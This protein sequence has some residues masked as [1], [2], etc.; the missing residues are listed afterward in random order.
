MRVRNKPLV[1]LV[2]LA[3]AA[4]ALAGGC[5]SD[6][7]SE[8]SQPP[9]QPPG[10]PPTGQ[11]FNISVT[12][13]P[14]T[15]EA[16][17]EESA[18]IRVEVRRTDNNQPPP[19]GTTVVISTTL[20]SLNA[21]G[22]PQSDVFELV[23]GVATALFFPPADP[24]TA[25]IRAQLQ[26]S[27]G[28]AQVQIA[29]ADALFISF[30][31]PPVGSPQGGDQVTIQGSGFEPPVRVTF[32][33]ANAQ[34]LS[35]SPN[36][37]RVVTP[38]SPGA[39]NQQQ[40][41][42]VTV[43]INVNEEEEASDTLVGGFT[44]SPGG[45]TDVPAVFSVTPGSGPNEGGTLVVINGEGFVAPVQVIFGQGSS[46]DNFEGQEAQIQSVTPNRIEVLSPAAVGFGQDNRDQLVAILVRN[47][48]S[49]LATVSPARFQYGT[50]VLITG[51]GPT[52]VPFFGGVPVIINGQGFDAP[53]AVT[54]GG[55]AQPATSVTGTEIVVATQP[56]VTSS[57]ADVTGP[58]SVT[59]LETGGSATA[60]GLTFTYRVVAFSPEILDVNPTAGPQS[61]NT[62]VT[63]TGANLFNSRVLFGG[64]PASVG[65][66]SPDGTSVTVQTPF[67]PDEALRT[68]ACDDNM[69]G[70]NGQRFLPTAVDVTVI[71]RDTTCQDT[72][73]DAFVYNPSNTSCRNDVGAPP[74]EEP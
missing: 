53:V 14:G 4:A 32:G 30:V 8:P 3:A 17:G 34:V 57:C 52:I 20:G 7:P 23:N 37:I 71:N 22:G 15:L 10:Q 26:G 65:A 25:I 16:G 41:V 62:P 40:N 46:P 13:T 61:G 64:R 66:E 11:A 38:P 47:L 54:L 24:G 35:V 1:I 45:S 21:P 9:G 72:F 70:T 31:N 39:G 63:I 50:P 18:T 55:I 69:D 67:L 42:N 49:G 33:G 2:L 36:Q 27:V 73:P 59:N 19:N 74:P 6:S 56:I 43:T 51:V 29:E 12:V 28:Q 58:V 60:E 5:S 68:E 48:A 44:F